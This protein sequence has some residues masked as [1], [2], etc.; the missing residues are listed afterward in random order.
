MPVGLRDPEQLGNDGHRNE[1]EEVR[2]QI[3]LAKGKGAIDLT[4]NDHLDQRSE[5]FHR[6]WGEGLEHEPSEPGVIGRLHV[7][8]LNG[9]EIPERAL[10]G[11]RRGAAPGFV[12]RNMK[13]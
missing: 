7:N 3:E 6:A 11:W 13:V 9:E 12:A 1:L 4:I 2:D 5:R 10:V 8:H